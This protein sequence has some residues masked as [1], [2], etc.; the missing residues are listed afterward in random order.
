M[1]YWC[2]KFLFEWFNDTFLC[3]HIGCTL[4]LML[5]DFISIL[6]IMVAL[7]TSDGWRWLIRIRQIVVGGKQI[8]HVHNFCIQKVKLWGI[9]I[10]VGFLKKMIH[11]III[12]RVS[13]CLFF[14]LQFF[15]FFYRWHWV[16]GYACDFYS[17]IGVR[18]VKLQTLI[19]SKHNGVKDINH[20]QSK[21][22]TRRNL[23][24]VCYY[25]QVFI[26]KLYFKNEKT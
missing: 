7:E 13:I 18:V 24:Y 25:I 12:A 3:Q 2:Y 21:N 23:K 1:T 16:C 17:D 19:K 15:N 8:C 9:G 10:L 5:E 26:C 6:N 14:F 4:Q 11:L 22:S 20:L